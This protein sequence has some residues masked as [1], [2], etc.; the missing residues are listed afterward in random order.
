MPVNPK[1]FGIAEKTAEGLMGNLPQIKTERDILSKQYD[2]IVLLDV[3]DPDTSKKARELRLRI[4]DNR[5]KGIE[6]WHRT[7]KDFFLKGG[8]FVDAIKR[9]EV[10]VNNRMEET[11]E[12]IEKHF[13]LKEQKRL[14]DLREARWEDTK[15]L[16]DYIP[17]QVDLGLLSDEEYKKLVTGAKLQL[18]QAKAE[19]ERIR[20]EQEAEQKANEALRERKMELAPYKRFIDEEAFA[21]IDLNDDEVVKVLSAKKYNE[22]LKALKI[23]QT[24]YEKEQEEIRKENERLKQEQEE[25]ERKAEEDRI[26]EEKAKEKRFA[27]RMELLVGA[28]L[29]YDGKIFGIDGVFSIFGE[30]VANQTPEEFDNTLQNATRLVKKHREDEQRAKEEAEARK[31]QEEEEK[32]AKEE[33]DRLAK[34]PVVERLKKWVSGFAIAEFGEDNEVAKKINSEFESFLH[35]ADEFIEAFEEQSNA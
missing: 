35:R 18:E 2:E 32:R 31:K 33:A 22:I 23:R 4:R 5:T 7:T 6:V 8:Q 21:G 13:E 24:A 1:E 15:D 28:G 3:D 11:L 25:R 10:E 12:K 20:K 29:P 19:E 34:A 16:R 9:K 30:T 27:S 26:A 17:T 14:Q